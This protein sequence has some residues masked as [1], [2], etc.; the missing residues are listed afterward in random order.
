MV[1]LQPFL[2][3]LPLHD[4]LGHIFMLK[5]VHMCTHKRLLFYNEIVQGNSFLK[6][7][8]T[9]NNEPCYTILDSGMTHY[10]VLHIFDDDVGC[11]MNLAQLKYAMLVTN[12]VIV[13]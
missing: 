6:L 12:I 9:I 11:V 1:N 7:P 3:C 13:L 10:F 5:L 8:Y 4:W 2:H